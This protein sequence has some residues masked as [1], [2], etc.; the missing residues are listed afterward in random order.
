MRIVRACLV[1]RGVSNLKFKKGQMVQLALGVV[2]IFALLI[3]F[4]ALNLV[5]KTVNTSIQAETDISTEAKAVSADVSAS[6]DNVFDQG[7]MMVLVGI[8]LLVMA[9]A[10]V[11]ANN[12]LFLVVAVLVLASL[13]FVGMILSNGYSEFSSDVDVAAFA[14]DFPM[15]NF[16][17]NNYL[18]VVLV[19][20]FSGVIVYLYRSVGGYG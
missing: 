16:I 20:G 13:G 17:L 3:V 8:W 7:L 14:A 11:G 6:Y 10:Y 4:V 15:S 2:L 18:V 5:T 19:I 9:L 12:P 1:G